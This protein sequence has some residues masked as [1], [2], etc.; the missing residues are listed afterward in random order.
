MLVE[1][2]V[3]SAPDCLLCK[4]AEDQECHK[5]V[6]L[7]DTLHLLTFSIMLFVLFLDL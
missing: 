2:V 1:R 4:V 6:M 3:L 5:D 7:A